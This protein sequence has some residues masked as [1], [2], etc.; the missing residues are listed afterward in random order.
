MKKCLFLLVAV[1]VAIIGVLTSCTNTK[2]S[3]VEEALQA[4]EQLA[5]DMVEARETNDFQR[6]MEII[7]EL[8]KMEVEYADIKGDRDLNDAQRKRL[9]KVMEKII[10][11]GYNLDLNSSYNKP[12]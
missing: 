8:K 10:A 3:R 1:V 11:G 6:Q 7:V 9:S 4:Y 12:D 5:D 2:S